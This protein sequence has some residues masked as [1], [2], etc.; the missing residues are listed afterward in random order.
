MLTDG[1]TTSNLSAP[2]SSMARNASFSHDTNTS[3]TPRWANVV[4]AA[5]APVSSTGAF[6]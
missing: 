5:R 4:S 6:A 3:P 2:N 1:A